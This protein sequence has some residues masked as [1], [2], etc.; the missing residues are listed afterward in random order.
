MVFIEVNLN[1]YFL[2]VSAGQKSFL[3]S[4]PG[5]IRS[6]ENSKKVTLIPPGVGLPSLA[7]SSP[8]GEHPVGKCVLPGITLP[9]L[10]KHPA[11]ANPSD[12][13]I[14]KQCGAYPEG[15]VRR[16]GSGVRPGRGIRSS[17]VPRNE[18]RLPRICTQGTRRVF[19]IGFHLASGPLPGMGE[20]QMIA[21]VKGKGI[22]SS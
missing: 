2:V 8:Q 15:Y 3:F 16:T 5:P 22:F 13:E 11:G 4:S 18:Y 6:A 1:F 17:F 7:T 21:T 20:K 9:S 14:A 19:P 10:A 12:L